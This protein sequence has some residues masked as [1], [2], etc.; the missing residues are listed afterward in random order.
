[1]ISFVRIAR[2]MA[3]AVLLI[4][5]SVVEAEQAKQD[6]V[7][8]GHVSPEILDP[9]KHGIG[10]AISDVLLESLF[11]GYASLQDSRGDVGTVI[12]VRDPECPVSRAY[13]PRQAQM[14]RDYQ[15]RGFNF[16]VLYLNEELS[17]LDLVRDASGF[18]G[19]ALFVKGGQEKLAAQ[20]GVSSTGDVFVLDAR[21]RLRYRGAVD[22]QYGI[23]YTRDFAT[24]R[25]L[26]NALDALF[27]G[28]PV[29]I[30]ATSAPGCFID[31]D[32]AKDRPMQS[33]DPYE[34]VS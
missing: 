17:Q 28:E 34:R 4:S 23:G 5:G 26:R 14:A 15:A 11:G 22:D 16:V 6:R 12:V 29:A 25:L 10:K 19:P 32:P 8:S 31:A 13:G 30:P 9:E 7:P 2:L 27:R 20:L 18:D 1:M 3:V 33:W 21:Q 24:R